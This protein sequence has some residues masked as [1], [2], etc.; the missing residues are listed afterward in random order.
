VDLLPLTS[1]LAAMDARWAILQPWLDALQA[2]LVRAGETSPRQ[3]EQRS[4]CATLSCWPAIW[5]VGGV[6]AE[7]TLYVELP[8]DQASRQEP[9]HLQRIREAVT[10]FETL[11]IVDIAAFEACLAEHLR[12]HQTEDEP[13]IAVWPAWRLSLGGFLSADDAVAQAPYVTW[14]ELLFGRRED[15]WE[16]SPGFCGA[17]K[18]LQDEGA[19]LVNSHRIH[20]AS[21]EWEVQIELMHIT[22]K[23]H[24]KRVKQTFRPLSGELEKLMMMEAPPIFVIESVSDSIA[25]LKAWQAAPIARHVGIEAEVETTSTN[26]AKYEASGIG[27]VAAGLAHAKTP[28]FKLRLQDFVEDEQAGRAVA[29]AGFF[30]G[31]LCSGRAVCHLNGVADFPA[32]E[33]H[34]EI[35]C[36]DA[37]Y[38]RATDLRF[39]GFFSAIAEGK[40]IRKIKVRTYNDDGIY[41]DPLHWRWLAYAFWS[42]ASN[43]CVRALNVGLINLTE[44]HVSAIEAVLKCSYP[45]P[46]EHPTPTLQS[47]YRFANI[48]AGTELRPVGLRGGDDSVLVVSRDVR[49][50]AHLKSS[51]VG[52]QLGVVVPGYGICTMP[53][54]DGFE[55]GFILRFP[56]YG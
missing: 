24:L 17:M 6:I 40:M 13:P 18:R 9:Y 30:F 3:D 34:K 20:N 1:L 45:Q 35:R 51:A 27:Q 10:I 26:L 56:C 44:E 38:S 53:N 25:L 2:V 7:R 23:Q 21:I 14:G 55:S 49:C 42:S 36:L 32:V 48:L 47:Q 15:M 28:T 54:V 8:A 43:T 39:G 12:A 37:I 29:S 16:H 41:R 4:A 50:R 31:V 19:G 11:A 5:D 52:N 46:A 33:R 22:G